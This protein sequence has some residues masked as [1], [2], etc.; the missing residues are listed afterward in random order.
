MVLNKKKIKMSPSF[1]NQQVATILRNVAAAYELEG[2]DRFRVNAYINAANSI[3]QI[4]IPLQLLWQEKRLDE[5]PGI[6][7]NLHEHIDEL[8]STG[9]VK[10]FDTVLKK[11]PTGMFELM[12]IPGIGPKTAQKL[13]RFLHI[14]DSKEAIEHLARAVE[15]NKIQG[16]EGF[17]SVSEAKIARALQSHQHRDKKRIPLYQAQQVA[18]DAITFLKKR[19]NVKDAQALGSLRRKSE[20][21]GDI[22]IAVATTTSE[23]VFE[24][25]K[26]WSHITS[27]VSTGPKMMTCIHMSGLQIDIKTQEPNKWGSMLQHYTG[28]KLHNIHL[29]TLA[30]KKTLS[31]SEYGITKAGQSTT[32]TFESEEKFYAALGMQWI[33]PELREDTGEIELALQHNLPTLIELRD[34][35]GDFHIHTNFMYPSSHDQGSSSIEE[36][37]EKAIALDYSYVGFSD[38]NP[39]QS[40]LSSKERLEITTQRSMW[41]NKEVAQYKKKHTHCPKV[42]IGMEVDILPDGELALED[43]ALKTL[44]YVIASVHSVFSQSQEQVT[45][46]LLKAL[47]NPY[48]RIF[49]HPTGRLIGSREG[50]SPNWQ[51]V[52]KCCAQQNIFLEINASPNRLDLPDGLIKDAKAFGC[53]FLIDT[54]AHA[55]DSL[56]FMHNGVDV[57]RRGWLTK[58]EVANTQLPVFFQKNK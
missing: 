11:Q 39:K 14:K 28:S 22:D 29:R 24:Q 26:Q 45:K 51:T 56:D 53:H 1:T 43:E 17:S 3:E 47:N 19:K 57:A 4:S 23:D 41:I 9:K 55:K 46:R 7:K 52:F 44:D 35:K 54:D 16:L 31:L 48:V 37:L 25:L 18:N 6:G 38:H 20:T 58:K 27:I 49:G 36:L 5:I 10:H 21:V 34:I 33:P 32:K 2:E 40:G 13:A 50:I 8:F 30:Q 15:H 42:F 12:T